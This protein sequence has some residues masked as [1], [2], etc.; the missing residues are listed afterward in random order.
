MEKS[1]KTIQS[2]LDKNRMALEIDDDFNKKH[3]LSDKVDVCEACWKYLKKKR[4]PPMAVANGL[5]SE[6]VPDVLKDLNEIELI[7]IQRV[8]HI[9]VIIDELFFKKHCFR[10]SS[11]LKQ[12]ENLV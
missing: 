1:K 2:I 6:E 8:R 3:K 12:L 7:C 9:Q 10:L 5:K 11:S 4:V